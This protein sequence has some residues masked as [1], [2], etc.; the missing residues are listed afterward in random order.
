MKEKT[1]HSN[2]TKLNFIFLPPLEGKMIKT[3]LRKSFKRDVEIL[4]NVYKG[5][6]SSENNV[7]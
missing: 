1:F 6:Y 3:S 7:F 2:A 5:N 4:E